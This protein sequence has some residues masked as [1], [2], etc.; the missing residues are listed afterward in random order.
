ME[1]QGI[2]FI[3]HGSKKEASNEEFI[4][5]CETISHNIQNFSHKKAAFLELATPSIQ[6]V[7]EEF[8]EDGVKRIVCY[9]F[10]L[11]SGKHVQVDIPNIIKELQTLNSEVKFELLPH[12]GTSAKINDIIVNDINEHILATKIF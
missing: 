3:A 8:L 6:S 11:N 12:F 4:L 5:M 2:I 7:V 1:N 10:F 9:P